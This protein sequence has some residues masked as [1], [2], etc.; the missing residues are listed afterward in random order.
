MKISATIL[1]LNLTIS[2]SRCT[3]LDDVP[4]PAND[5]LLMATRSSRTEVKSTTFKIDGVLFEIGPKLR[6]QSSRRCG[7]GVVAQP[8]ALY[9]S[10]VTP[11]IAQPTEGLLG[12]RGGGEQ[13]SFGGAARRR[14][15]I[16]P[17]RAFVYK[18]RTSGLHCGFMEMIPGILHKPT[19][20]APFLI[21]PYRYANIHTHID[22]CRVRTHVS[23]L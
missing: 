5:P 19:R 4:R 12:S 9:V 13:S 8:G 14:F 17:P 20:P 21:A 23:H 6:G 16:G 18:P 3:E 11:G 22:A 2:H 15:L 7:G 10:Q 1:Y